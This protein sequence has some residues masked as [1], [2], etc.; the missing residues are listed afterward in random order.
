MD[1][2]EDTNI[3][4]GVEGSPRVSNPVGADWRW[5]PQGTESQCRRGRDPCGRRVG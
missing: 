5:Q 3:M 1:G 2:R 4:C